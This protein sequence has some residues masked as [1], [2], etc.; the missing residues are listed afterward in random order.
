L[1][2]AK[3][4]VDPNVGSV[5]TGQFSDDGRYPAWH[6]AG[7]GNPSGSGERNCQAR[8]LKINAVRKQLAELGLD[9]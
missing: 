7:P 5:T 2:L 6:E 9:R 3:E 4:V 8:A 1:N